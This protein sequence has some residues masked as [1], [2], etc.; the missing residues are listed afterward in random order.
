VNIYKAIRKS[1][2][3][4]S[5]EELVAYLLKIPTEKWVDIRPENQKWVVAKVTGKPYE[6][7]IARLAPVAPSTFMAPFVE[8]ENPFTEQHYKALRARMPSLYTER[9]RLYAEQGAD[10]PNMP[11]IHTYHSAVLPPPFGAEFFAEEV[12]V[13]PSLSKFLNSA[14]EQAFFFNVQEMETGRVLA[15][16][17]IDIIRRREAGEVFTRPEDINIS[18]GVPSYYIDSGTYKLLPHTSFKPHYAI[19]PEALSRSAETYETGVQWTVVPGGE[20]KVVPEQGEKDELWDEK[21]IYVHP[22]GLPLVN[23]DTIPDSEEKK[24]VLRIMEEK[25][26]V[27]DTNGLVN[28]DDINGTPEVMRVHPETLILSGDVM[29]LK[30]IV[31]TQSVDFYSLAIAKGKSFVTYHWT[32][33]PGDFEKFN[34]KLATSRNLRELIQ[35]LKAEPSLKNLLGE[36]QKYVGY[37]EK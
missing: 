20:G 27:P 9:S 28:M 24:R 6:E 31:P 25:G 2:N 10:Y 8:G 3:T 15:P 33:T 35:G 34:E 22:T 32:L 17:E 13:P 1:G 26:I 37:S 16:Q 36:F 30:G 14:N 18:N 29:H 11:M 4:A 23:P 21:A 7:E 5:D 19:Y 12:S